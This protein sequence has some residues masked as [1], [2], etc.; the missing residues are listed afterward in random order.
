MN[1]Q[2]RYIAVDVAAAIEDVFIVLTVKHAIHTPYM[3]DTIDIERVSYNFVHYLVALQRDEGGHICDTSNIY[4]HVYEIKVSIIFRV[5]RVY[6]LYVFS[7]AG[8]V[9]FNKNQVHTHTLEDSLD[10]RLEG[11]RH[12]VCRLQSNDDTEN[13]YKKLFD[14]CVCCTTCT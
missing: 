12:L 6:V 7:F 9:C 3:G 11:G 10:I 14:Y 13:I 1:G 2:S 8:E 4:K 5:F